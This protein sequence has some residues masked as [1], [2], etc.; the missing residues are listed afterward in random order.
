MTPLRSVEAG[1][2]LVEYRDQGPATEPPRDHL[3]SV[4]KALARAV[5]L[6]RPISETELVPLAEASGRVLAE[7]A[8][9]LGPLPSFD[10]AAMDGY[11]VR[12][13]ELI[14]AGPWQLPVV[15]RVAAG[16]LAP[17][18]FSG[19]IRIL[20]GAPV[21]AGFDAVVMQERVRRDGG[22]IR[23]DTIPP[24]GDNIRRAGEDLAAGAPI[25]SAGALIGVRET[26]ALAAAG[27]ARP[28]VRRRVRIATLVTGDELLPAGDA[29]GPGHIWDANGPMLAAAV[30]QPWIERRDFG[31]VHD[32]PITLTKAL[33]EAASWADLVVT[34]GG[35]SV[36]DADHMGRALARTGGEV[37]VKQ[38]AMKPGKPILIGRIGRSVHIGLP[39]TPL[40][41]FVGW[42]LFG[43]P[44]VAALAGRPPC[45][46]DIF[47]RAGF[48]FERR[49]G[50][51]EFRPARRVGTDETG[52]QIVEPITERFTHSLAALAAADGLVILPADAKQ[53][54][55]GDLLRFLPL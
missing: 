9:A 52:A 48:T 23:L 14:G 19:A 6:A 43:A 53:I 37:V 31:R 16:G 39:G 20:T 26:A 4:E 1:D 2:A 35:V 54:L 11:A 38:V 50:R 17:E 24:A 28:H 40:S 46:R 44:C 21:P 30:V 32:D 45:R 51:C 41:A 55:E 36:G 5:A 47:V 8:R 10:S 22:V 27:I 33:S 15:G 18:A 25:L 29:L 13:V 49:P 12:R 7:G 42:T 34:S 3:I